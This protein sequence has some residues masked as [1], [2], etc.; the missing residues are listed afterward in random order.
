MASHA[1][2]AAPANGVR[3][4]AAR[5]RSRASRVTPRSSA[6]RPRRL[7]VARSSYRTPIPTKTGPTCSC[8]RRRAAR[9]PASSPSN[10]A[11][12]RMAEIERRRRATGGDDVAVVDDP[13]IPATS[14]PPRP[15]RRG[16]AG[17]SPPDGPPA[18]RRRPTAS[19]RCIPRPPP[20]RH[21]AGRPAR[22]GAHRRTACARR[23]RRRAIPAGDDDQV[24]RRP[25]HIGNL[26]RQPVSGGDQRRVRG[27]PD[28]A[29]RESGG[30][31]HLQRRDGVEIVKPVEQHDLGEGKGASVGHGHMLSAG[32]ALNK[33]QE[34]Q[35]SSDSCQRT[36][37]RVDSTRSTRSTR[38]T[39]AP[40]A[41]AAGPHRVVALAL[42]GVVL[43]DLAA[44][45]HLFGHL[46]GR[47]YR[48][49]LAGLRPGGCGSRPA[50]TWSPR[51]VPTRWRPP[52]RS[53]CPAWPTTA[54]A[55]TTATAGAATTAMAAGDGA[56]G[57][58]DNAL[59]AAAELVAAAATP[60]APGRCRYPHRGVRARRAGLLDGRR[61][62]HPWS[63][64]AELPAATPGRGRPDGALC[65]RGQ[66]ADQRRGCRRGWAAPYVIRRDHGGAVAAATAGAPW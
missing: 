23:G 62:H 41:Q 36:G 65:R 33:W 27:R 54:A 51:W 58:D 60:G 2:R 30:G 11:T 53:S 1:S 43:L 49:D 37:P 24:G 13:R 12:R 59:G 46:G 34:C 7:I 47:R 4:T 21:G 40:P 66:R 22:R 39:G 61:C 29:H 10:R 17:W 16:P 48:S 15:G 64:A 55:A 63:A 32:R 8:S 52:T 18:G 56:G 26:D 42:D 6:A 19:P 38:S 9:A 20:F 28:R 31:Q 57:D 14:A 50:S 25:E 44:P 3:L 35:V 45:T 5:E